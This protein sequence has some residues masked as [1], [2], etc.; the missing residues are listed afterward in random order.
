MPPQLEKD[1]VVPTS[2]Q[3]EVLARYGVSREVP[4]S[5]LKCETV[6][7]TLHATH[8]KFPETPGSLEG[9]TEGPGATSSE[10][11]LPF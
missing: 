7:D 5:V 8:Q 2:S 6:P 3:D 11:L 10:H 4:G 1:H 9:N